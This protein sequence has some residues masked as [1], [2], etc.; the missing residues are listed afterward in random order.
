MKWA[1]KNDR[2]ENCDIIFDV[3]HYLFTF[4]PVWVGI[5]Y[6]SKSTLQ[7]LNLGT[8]QSMYGHQ[9]YQIVIDANHYSSEQIICY[10]NY[11]L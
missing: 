3:L 6:L 4:F 9:F 8:N 10:G 1:Y 7:V 11:I 2:F 5:S